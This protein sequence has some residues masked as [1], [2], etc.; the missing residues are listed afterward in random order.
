MVRFTVGII[1]RSSFHLFTHFSLIFTLEIVFLFY[2]SSFGRKI[3]YEKVVSMIWFSVLFFQTEFSYIMYWIIYSFIFEIAFLLKCLWI[4]VFF[5]YVLLYVRKK[6]SR[7]QILIKCFNLLILINIL[8]TEF[9]KNFHDPWNW[10]LIYK[11]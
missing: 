2:P 10:E 1:S 3:R 7:F 8:T 5:F 11:I 6:K 4:P 9:W